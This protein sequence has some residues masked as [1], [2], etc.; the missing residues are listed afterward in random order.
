MGWRF[1]D[2]SSARFARVSASQQTGLDMANPHDTAGTSSCPQCGA[3][4]PRGAESWLC[5]RCLLGQA[6]A[7]AP[8]IS[9]PDSHSPLATPQSDPVLHYFG[10]YALIEEIA[11]GGMGVVYRGRQLSLNRIVAVKML[12]GGRFSSSESMQR[13]RLEAE[14]AANLHH[15]NIV[16]IHEIGEHDGQPYFSMDYVAGGDLATLAASGPLAPR[17][18]AEL[19]RAVA[20]AVYHAH[21]RGL[22]HRDLKPSNILIDGNGHPHVT[23]FGLAKRLIDSQPSNQDSLNTLTLTGQIL[24]TPAYMSPEQARG[25]RDITAATDL[26]SLGALLYFLLTARAPFHADSV[27]ATLRQVIEREPMAPSL[28]NPLIPRDLETVCLK[29]L[30]K[31]P[32]RRYASAQALA[33][34]L[35]RFLRNE[36]INAQPTGALD[37]MWRWCRRKPLVAGLT[38]GLHLAIALGLIGISWQWQKTKAHAASEAQQ[39][40]LAEAAKLVATEKLR[41]AYLAQARAIRFSG[42]PGRRFDSIA[43]LSAAAAL[44]GP[45]GWTNTLRDEAIACLSQ[46]DTR[47]LRRQTN[48]AADASIVFDANLQLYAVGWSK[49][50]EIQI[51]RVIDDGEV[52]RLPART[53]ALRKVLCFSPDGRWLAARYAGGETRA[54]NLVRRESLHAGPSTEVY[55]GSYADFRPGAEEMAVGA[56]YEQLI[57]RNLRTGARRITAT[58]PFE[59]SPNLVKYSPDGSRIAVAE[60]LYNLVLVLDADSVSV[61]TVIRLPQTIRN[62]AWDANG[63][64]IATVDYHR[65]V[66]VW[67]ATTGE[68]RFGPFVH[69]SEIDSVAF[70]GGNNLLLSSGWDG[71]TVWNVQTGAK[72]WHV[73]EPRQMVQPGADGRRFVRRD[74][75]LAWFEVCERTVDSPVWLIGPNQSEPDSERRAE[76][77]AQFSPDGTFLAVATGARLRLFDGVSRREVANVAIAGANSVAFD[78]QTNLWLSGRHGL[79]RWPLALGTNNGHWTLGPP[80][81]VGAAVPMGV[82]AVSGNGRIIAAGQGRQANVF[83]ARTGSLLWQ[84]PTHARSIV[85]LSVDHDGRF[86]AAGG[87]NLDYFTLHDVVHQSSRRLALPAGKQDLTSPA[88]AFNR[89]GS[90][91]F[92]SASSAYSMWRFPDA[93]MLWSRSRAFDAPVANYA[94]NGAFVVQRDR[95]SRVQLVD[96]ATG[97][98]VA[99]LSGPG[100]ENVVR[101]AVSPDCTRLA[102]SLSETPQ[103]VVW[104]LR[105][106]RRE[107]ARIG[108][109]W[110]QETFTNPP[111]SAPWVQVKVD[112]RETNPET[113]RRLRDTALPAIPKR[114]PTAEA[115]CIDLSDRFNFALKETWYPTDLVRS[116]SLGILPTGIV[117]MAGVD[118][119]VRGV[120]QLCGTPVGGRNFPTRVGGIRLDRACRSLHVLHAVRGTEL[121]RTRIG[122]YVF[123]YVDGSEREWPIIYGENVRDFK[124]RENEPVA[125]DELVEAWSGLTSGPRSPRLRLFASHWKNPRPGAEIASMDF[126]SEM[127]GCEPFLV[128]VTAH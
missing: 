82:M 3:P 119:D 128:A 121:D 78:A 100:S 9:R 67:D 54:W 30:H 63:Q 46:P 104:N 108:L 35:G 107:L 106:L 79:Q 27:E 6:A 34:D 72:L 118:F 124:T 8:A 52:F 49:S 92:V 17:R 32:H 62:L 38:A 125:P 44:P 102:V 76:N 97:Q 70:E 13:F 123:H 31:E 109:D 25:S 23:D 116:N 41:E 112:V 90:R 19:L 22:L 18:A 94:P 74:Y 15:P 21:E 56:G 98:V 64:W 77:S 105:E 73:P 24:G 37:R 58:L 127:T 16:A 111:P 59:L 10:D 81:F 26:Y 113:Q 2:D 1:T 53:N 48:F 75:H 20:E 61:R 87:W 114:P 122:R 42:Q 117:R 65:S 12:A 51:R 88:V 39:R 7:P 103:T 66:L 36:P 71:T 101:F 95:A 14:A 91:L 40:Q 29:C 57:I 47:V 96:A 5:P 45:P 69:D 55:N 60:Y 89:D 43:A 86:V 99:S 4:L 93:A 110:A 85:F 115:A 33:D 84:T 120:V 80:E 68:Q 83:D 50:G 126:E 11:R 28:L